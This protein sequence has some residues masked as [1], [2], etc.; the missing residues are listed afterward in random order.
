MSAIA[1]NIMKC[2]RNTISEKQIILRLWVVSGT[3]EVQEFS[4]SIT[5]PSGIKEY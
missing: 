3:K 1:D 5:V 4:E 2:E